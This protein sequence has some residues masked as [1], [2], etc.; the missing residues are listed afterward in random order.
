MNLLL[1]SHVVMWWVEASPRVKGAWL[2][3]LLDSDNTVYVSAATAWEIEIKKRS[4]KLAFAPNIVDVAT[5]YGWELLAVSGPD[6]VGAGSLDWDHRDPFDRMLVAQS[7]ARGMV[8]VTDDAALKSAP[9][10]RT[11]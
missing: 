9:G 10:I 4:G 6:A 8:L 3:P 2:E 7:L 11:L 5:E 1:D